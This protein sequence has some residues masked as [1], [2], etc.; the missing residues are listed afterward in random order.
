VDVKDDP[1]YRTPVFEVKSGRSSCP[2]EPWWGDAVN[3]KNPKTQ[4]RDGSF[5]A[6]GPEPTLSANPAALT[7][8]KIA[9]D[10]PATFTLT[11]KNP[12]DSRE[13]RE[14]LLLPIQTSNPF[15][16]RLQVNGLPLS[17]SGILFNIAPDRQ[18]VA[19]LTVERGPY[20]YYYGGLSLL[21]V[22]ACEQK[23]DLYQWADT[24]SVD[25]AFEA[26][27]SD[28]ELIRPEAGWRVGAAD[29]A[30]VEIVMRPTEL[31]ISE[32][33]QDKVELVGAEYRLKDP[34][35]TWQKILPT[36]PLSEIPGTVGSPG[37]VTP[38]S[39]TASMRCTPTPDVEAKTAASSRG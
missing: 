25:V 14:F 37:S 21:M 3:H 24:V 13:E 16:A 31:Q 28:I 32:L 6:N 5:T 9:P 29:A 18:Q 7:D 15:G 10:E 19:T 4:P 35:A 1:L 30:T 20:N 11:L 39:P 2:W 27:C 23:M 33:A 8:P 26:P 38:A 34:A 17:S 36:V 22:P 12:S